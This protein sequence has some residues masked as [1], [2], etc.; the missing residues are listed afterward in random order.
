MPISTKEQK[1]KSRGLN[2]DEFLATNEDEFLNTTE[3]SQWLKV[4][5]QWLRNKRAFEVDHLM[6]CAPTVK[7]SQVQQIRGQEVD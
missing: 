2:S 3:M 7:P 6:R 4:S 1:V 5:E